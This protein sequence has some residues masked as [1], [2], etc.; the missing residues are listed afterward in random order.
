MCRPSREE[1]AGGDD[2]T[3]AEACRREVRVLLTLDLDFADVRLYP[4]SETPGI[5]VLR[6]H[7]QTITAELSLVKQIARAVAQTSPA[8]ELWVVEPGRLRIR[9]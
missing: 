9:G 4:P 6:P 7:T 8:G 3:I 2:V 5:I 1:L